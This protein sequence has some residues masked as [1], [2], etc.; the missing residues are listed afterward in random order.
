MSATL[1]DIATEA[2]RGFETAHRGDD[3]EQP[4]TRLRDEYRDTWLYEIVYDAHGDFLP[5][6]WRFDCIRAACGFLADMD[7]SDDPD[8]WS[9]EFADSH[10]DAY[11]AAR[12]AWLASHIQRQ[13]Y[14][15]EATAEFG[16][17]ET[18]TDAIGRGQYLEAREVFEAVLQGLR[19]RLDEIADEDED[20]DD[21]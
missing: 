5:D 15:D 16:P 21:D 12:F 13:G 2:Y 3:P 20:G 4:F 18:I 17:A 7:G 6:D 19:E 14:C 11:N 10:V 9:H 1:Q 8:D